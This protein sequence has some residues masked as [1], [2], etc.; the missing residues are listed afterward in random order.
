MAFTTAALSFS[1]K[2]ADDKALLFLVCPQFFQGPYTL[3]LA[4]DGGLL[5]LQIPREEIRS[6]QM[7]SNR[8]GEVFTEFRQPGVRNFW[9]SANVDFK[10]SAKATFLPSQSASQIIEILGLEVTPSWIQYLISSVE[11][12]LTVS[13]ILKNLTLL[14]D[15]A[16]TWKFCS[17]ELV[18]L[19][20]GSLL[21]NG[22]VC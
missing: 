14:R 11:P 7:Y 12:A 16:A 19:G 9:K 1:L 20:Y 22:S 13:R 6:F 18:C 3:P 10:H 21:L 17:E 4:G 5:Q 2:G 15:S 8:S